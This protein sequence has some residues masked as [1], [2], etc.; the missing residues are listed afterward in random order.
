MKR[1]PVRFA[2]LLY[3]VMWVAGIAWAAAGELLAGVGIVLAATAGLV[4][5]AG[6]ELD[7]AN[8]WRAFAAVVLLSAGVA[9]IGAEVLLK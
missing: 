9:A 6:R 7:G 1:I 3:T 2:Q 8:G 5:P 4:A